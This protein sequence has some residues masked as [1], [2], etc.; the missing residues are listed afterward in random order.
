MNA[1]HLLL[2]VSLLGAAGL[3]NATA[4]DLPIASCPAP[5]QETIRA[6]TG[7]GKLDDIKLIT[8]GGA[9]EY[10]V[11]IDVPGDRDRKLHISP[12]GALLKVR[13]NIP[14]TEAP[15][16]VQEA[17][18][19]LVPT[20]GRVDDVRKTTAGTDISFEVEIDRP[21]PDVWRGLS[22]NHVIF[23]AVLHASLALSQPHLRPAIGGKP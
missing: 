2:T 8:A 10:V 22:K 20:G 23:S 6:Q 15:A 1:R 4:K 12:A 9:Q 14:L 21:N 11:D 13:E 19:K 17:A 5:V 18:K 7:S 3:T 16:A